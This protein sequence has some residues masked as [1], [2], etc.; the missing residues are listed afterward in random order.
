MLEGEHLYNSF[1]P[2]FVLVCMTLE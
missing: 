2:A 1:D